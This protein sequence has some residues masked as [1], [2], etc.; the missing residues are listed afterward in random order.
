MATRPLLRIAG[1]IALLTL[2]GAL[3]YNNI[4][5]V[6]RAQRAE[7]AT[8]TADSLRRNA[9]EAARSLALLLSQVRA[10]R[11]T[12]VRRDTV[13]QE[14][15]RTVLAE[16][17][18]DTCK[19]V[20]ASRDTII[21]DQQDQIARWRGVSDRQLAATDSLQRFVINPLRESNDSLKTAVTLLRPRRFDFIGRLFH[22]EIK[23]AAFAG[24]CINGSPCVGVGVAIT[25]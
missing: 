5:S 23:P 19:K 8:E 6:R 25:F 12:L 7:R 4:E 21:L 20:V 10:K 17:V 22:P 1:V 15:V 11:D 14:R 24:V 13:L 2:G 16:P 3:V 18:P 9:T